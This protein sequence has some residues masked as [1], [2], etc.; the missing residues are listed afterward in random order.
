MNV[1]FTPLCRALTLHQLNEIEVHALQPP[2]PTHA[3]TRTLIT[4]PEQ[5]QFLQ[6]LDYNVCVSAAVYTEWCPP[7]PPR[8]KKAFLVKKS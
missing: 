6:L 2:L 7:P 1:D 5:V 3:R 8:R 4:N